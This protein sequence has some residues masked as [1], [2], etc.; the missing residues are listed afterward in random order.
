MDYL[1]VLKGANQGQKIPLE[2][3]T[4]LVIGRSSLECDLVI[5][6]PAVSRTHAQI[7]RLQGKVFIEDL[8]SRNRTFVNNQPVTSRVPLKDTDLI[9]ICDFACSFHN[10]EDRRPLP[11]HLSR[12]GGPPV[13]A[14]TSST[15]EITLSDSSKKIL[16]TQPADRLAVLLEITSQLTQSFQID[17]LLPRIIERLFQLYKQA[18]RGF[19]ILVDEDTGELV[20]RVVQVR[21]ERDRSPP[22]FSRRL[23]NQCLE[24]GNAILS[25][26]VIN[27]PLIDPSESMT[28]S[29]IRSV[30]C[31]PLVAPDSGKA[32]GVILLDTQDS[33]RKFSEDDLKFLVA[34]ASQAALALQNA[35][36]LQDTQLREQRERDL[37]LARQV[38]LSI[39]PGQLPNLPGY[40]FFAHYASALEV[41]GDYYDFITLPDRRLAVT[42]GDVAGKGLPAALLMA[43]L[44]SDARSCLLN[45]SDAAA[46]IDRL[47]NLMYPFFDRN[48]GFVTLVVAVLDPEK[49][50]VTL[51]NAGHPPPLLYR[52]GGKLTEAAPAD[53]G[54][55]PVGVEMNWSY[56]SHRL[57]L[58]P[59]EGLMMFTDGV[60]DARDKN[61]LPFH[62]R[63]VSETLGKGPFTPRALGERLVA[64][65]KQHSLDCKQHDDI[66]VVCFG[67][68]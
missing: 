20:P 10:A 14:E 50:L 17:D 5:N 62:N 60:I 11:A 46:A 43:K 16:Q 31:V 34:V 7:L 66:T 23:V 39:L 57:R 3:K 52:G 55:V 56:T 40:D 33:P 28:E 21:Q 24:T 29:R 44:T 45:E 41:G 42:I 38:Q 19:I 54:G 8:K 12:T 58:G 18:D 51:V 49:H 27:D 30:M 6:D 22:R 65:V 68:V 59:G 4:R 64:A 37:A 1:F 63:R 35:R 9:K 25:K 53:V 36:H 26:D 47:N 13:E 61:D 67:R 2:G 15:I 32:F 48:H